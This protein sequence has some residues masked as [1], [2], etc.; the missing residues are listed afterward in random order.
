MP[1]FVT[2][3]PLVI[4]RQ[5]KSPGFY[6]LGG[7]Q[8]LYLRIR[9]AS[10]SYILRYQ[11]TFGK[12]RSMSLGLRRSMSLSEARTKATE[13][14]A[15]LSE[16]INPTPTRATRRKAKTQQSSSKTA[17]TSKT[18]AEVMDLWLKYRVE[19]NY[20]VNDRK[21]RSRTSSM[22]SS[23]TSTSDQ[24]RALMLPQE[25][26][27]LGQTREIVS[28]ENCK[29]ILCD[30]IRYYEDPDFTCRA[31]LPPPSIPKQDIDTFI[32]KIENR[33]RP[34]TAGE[35]AA[36][37]EAA[38]KVVLEGFQE[39]P[40]SAAAWGQDEVE[41]FV[42]FDVQAAL[43]SL[44]FA[45]RPEGSTGISSDGIA[46]QETKD[47]LIADIFDVTNTDSNATSESSQGSE[48][49]TVADA[50]SDLEVHLT[51]SED[52]AAESS[53]KPTADTEAEYSVNADAPDL[54]KTLESI[55]ALM[56]TSTPEQAELP[57]E[58]FYS[59][60]AVRDTRRIS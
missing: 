43:S 12:R 35:T 13:I 1:K 23:S 8:G 41:S 18:F 36:P 50:I 25:I 27:E 20:W 52:E 42:D 26:R 3:M 46:D 21:D 14:R 38:D 29:P 19:N 31:N 24:R 15:R 48:P 34:M 6:P 47:A 16:G 58:K 53:D 39:L 44:T 5:L 45:P 10:E 4:F 2:P 7:V 60:T 59:K 56:G 11:D 54:Q 57:I 55:D 9:G 49:A 22:N 33:T 40:Q 32:A 37:S 17:P 28:L 30:K 51:A